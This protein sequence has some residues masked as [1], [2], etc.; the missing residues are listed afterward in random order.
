VAKQLNDA[1]K[2]ARLLKRERRRGDSLTEIS[3]KLGGPAAGFSRATLHALINQ[4]ASETT[5]RK[6]AAAIFAAL[7]P[8]DAQEIPMPADRTPLSEDAQTYFGLTDDPFRPKARI[9]P[10]TN[11][12]LEAVHAAALNAVKSQGF[13]IVLGDVGSGKSTL[14]RRLVERAQ[15]DLRMKLIWPDFIQS[16]KVSPSSII[17][18]LLHSLNQTVP[19]NPMARQD[20]LILHL[21][22]L[23]RENVAVALGFDD[24]QDL[25][26]ETLAALK[27]MWE[28]E[29]GFYDLLGLVL[30]GQPQFRAR[31]AKVEFRQIAARLHVVEMPG[32]RSKNGKAEK[33]AWDY[34]AYRLSQV[35]GQAESLFEREAV[36][37][38]AKVQVTPLN[39][40]NAC[41]AALMRAFAAQEK[42]VTL[43]LADAKDDPAAF[44][45]AS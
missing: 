36:D 16:E 1:Q 33:T 24:C 38:L 32:F 34:V 6:V 18:Y 9:D 14:R 2:I 27:K 8:G 43:K 25:P 7:E 20:K 3:R 30:L 11:P 13:C 15:S 12:A 17:T 35:G 5:V 21:T 45:L 23:A 10:Y 22:Q 29:A 4:S 31:L 26:D 44:R 28:W 40:G 37:A 19:S 39:L 41:N 42:K